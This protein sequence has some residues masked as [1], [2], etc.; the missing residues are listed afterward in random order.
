MTAKAKRQPRKAHRLLVP[1]P[2]DWTSVRVGCI[3]LASTPPRHTEWFECL[4]VEA[5]GEEVVL[6]FCDWPDEPVFRRSIDQL[7]LL[8]PTHVLLPPLEPTKAEAQPVTHA[9]TSKG[10]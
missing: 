7:A 8:P 1:Q 3:V 10:P 2:H 5:E 4:V 9:I 6:R